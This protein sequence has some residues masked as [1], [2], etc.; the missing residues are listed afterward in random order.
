[1]GRERVPD[2]IR[3][4]GASS[5]V[6]GE[7]VEAGGK[8]AEVEKGL[9]EAGAGTAG[10][11]VD[12]VARAAHRIRREL[13]SG[14]PLSV[15]DLAISGRD[16]ISLG[17]KPGPHFGVILERLLDRV[18]DDPSANDPDRLRSWALELAEE[19]AGE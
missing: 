3:W 14:V 1:M 18:L 12:D 10:W 9:A 2:L 7:F 8:L 4:A 17:L 15:G 13:A 11:R 6:A 5:R 19:E 16:L